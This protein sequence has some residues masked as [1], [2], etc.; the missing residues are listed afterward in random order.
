[1]LRLPFEIRTRIWNLVL[2][3]NVIHVKRENLNYNIG[4]QLISWICVEGHQQILTQLL[5]GA[6]E[7]D[8]SEAIIVPLCDLTNNIDFNDKSILCCNNLRNRF[9]IQPTVKGRAL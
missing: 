5:S 6:S 8:S 4:Y 3:G 1:L 9:P 2:G 7:S